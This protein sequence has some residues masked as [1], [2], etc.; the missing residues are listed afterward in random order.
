VIYTRNAT[1]AP[2]R[3]EEGISG[4]LKAPTFIG[5]FQ[6]LPEIENRIGGYPRLPQLT[7]SDI[8]PVALDLEGRCVILEFPAFVLFGIYCPAH[9]D[10]DTNRE[11]FRIGFLRV[12][13]ARIRNL[14]EMGKRVI[15]AGDFNILR[16]ERDC[17][18][19]KES[20][21]KQGL[22]GQEFVSTPDR[23]IFNQLLVG[24]KVFGERDKGRETPIMW[25][26]CRGFHEQRLGMFTC[27]D[28]KINARPG[29]FGARIDYVL[30][31]A[32]MKDWFSESNIQ[33]GLFVGCF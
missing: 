22:D 9:R 16:E 21:R 6:D 32:D 25:D 24:G 12:L 17:A 8:N 14:V 33:E 18:A 28:T 4:I 19:P 27:W 30:C 20:M 13:D 15:I 23:R 5:S 1:C 26:I 31:S 10:G 7:Q 11:T 29:N 2:I 3:A